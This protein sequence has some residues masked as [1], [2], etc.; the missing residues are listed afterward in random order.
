MLSRWD[1]AWRYGLAVIFFAGPLIFAPFSTTTVNWWQYGLNAVVGLGGFVLITYRRRYPVLVGSAF[2]LLQIVVDSV[3]LF[4]LWSLVSV[5]TRRRWREIIAVGAATLVAM[6]LVFVGVSDR[7]G[8]TM[9]GVSASRPP[10]D[11]IE[12]S[13]MVVMGTLAVVVCISIGMYIGARRD[14]AASLRD[15]AETAEREQE[16]RVRQGQADER[17]RIAREMHDVLAHRLS[18]ISM[19]AGAL[20][21]RTDLSA[22]EMR[23]VAATIRDNSHHSLEE[24]RGVLGSLRSSDVEVAKPQPTLVQVPGL[25]EEARGLGVRVEY[26]SEVKNPDALPAAL[27]RHAYRIVQE[28]LTNARKHAPGAKVVVELSGA[29]GDGLTI[30]VR[31]PLNGRGG[32]VPGSGVGLLGLAERAAITGGRI[33]HEVGADGVFELRAWLPW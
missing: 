11:W 1:L 25:I 13:I 4:G 7:L 5:A 2:G 24:L 29:V 33:S 27:G 23:E 3:G 15:R 12:V 16:L 8:S 9:L 28:G 6:V 10:R 21:Y 17:N 18:L 31:N 26:S 22:D 32:A 30:V 19:H 14:W 20:A